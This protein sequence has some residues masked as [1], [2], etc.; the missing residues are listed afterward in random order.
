MVP[1]EFSRTARVLFIAIV[2]GL[3]G[4]DL[5]MMAAMV[6]KFSLIF[7]EMLDP[8]TPL[9]LATD[10][11][12]SHQAGLLV[13]LAALSAVAIAVLVTVRRR[14]ALVVTFLL[15]TV[16]LASLIPCIAF[17]LFLPLQQIVV[18]VQK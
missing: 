15:T 10:I 5:F 9:P 14:T 18:E 17:A 11:L 3:A 4:I 7:S 2:V 16:A 8:G 1:A 12:I 6:P 13:A